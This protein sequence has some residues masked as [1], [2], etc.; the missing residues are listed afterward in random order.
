M[1]QRAMIACVALAVLAACGGGGTAGGTITPPAPSPTPTPLPTPSPSLTPAAPMASYTP[2]AA[3]RPTA[4]VAI[5][6]GKCVNL[7]NHLEAPV[8]GA[9]GRAIVDG[10]FAIIKAAGFDT[11]RLPVRWS[12]HAMAAAP[13]TIDAAFLARVR[14]VV[15][16]A[17]AAKLNVLLNL[18]HYDEMAT[19]PAAHAERFA[20]LWKQIA[21]SF[22]DEPEASVWFELMNEPNG[23]LND[24]N[25]LGI[26]TPALAQV[27]A[28]NPTRAVVVGGQN[29][30]GVSSLAT[31]QLPDDPRLVVTIHT[32]DPFD[33]THQNATWLAPGRVPP[34][35]RSFGSAADLRELDANLAAVRAYMQRTGRQVFVGEY[36]ANDDPG[37]PLAQRILY[38]GTVSA[39]YASIGV[40]SCAWAYANTF[41]LRDGASWLPGMMEAIRTTTTLQ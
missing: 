17:R 16:T 41:R 25:L 24:S 13:Y 37:V 36:G 31:L 20:M 19:A 3:F 35:G 6:I 34:L 21:A 32:Y 38:Y 4:G 23:A 30:S 18:H 11:I 29:W 8:E 9:W 2:A 39:A 33:F 40:Q 12:N 14:H 7:G 1:K 27:R 22:A 28:T 5:P 15:D 26:L 10:D